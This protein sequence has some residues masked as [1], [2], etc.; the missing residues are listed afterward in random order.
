MLTSK[1][2]Y[3]VDVRLNLDKLDDEKAK[4]NHT[5]DCVEW[6]FAGRSHSKPRGDQAEDRIRLSHTVWDHW[7]DSK[8]NDPGIDEGDMCV[9]EDGDVLER[10]K[11]K[12]AVTGREIEYEELWHDLEVVPLGKK[13]N[14]S[15]LVLRVDNPENDLRGMA[16]KVGGW[17]QAILKVEDALTIERWEWKPAASTEGE[18]LAENDK[19][20]KRTPNDWV[21]TF[22]FGEGTL[23]CEYM[24]SNTV[25]K[26][27]LNAVLRHS[28]ERDEFGTYKPHNDYDRDIETGW[29]VLEEYYW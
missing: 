15:S 1:D 10:G 18:D 23:P 13:H 4:G 28:A 17:C 21:R 16:V 6:A 20:G 5:E 26:I 2:S 19:A 12:D 22:R 7:I 3:F 8:S 24:C 27:G 29:R 14:R 11:S 9:Q 25:G